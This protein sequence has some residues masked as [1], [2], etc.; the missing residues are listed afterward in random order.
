MVYFGDIDGRVGVVF[1]VLFVLGYI[2]I[3]EKGW[4]LLCEL[5]KH[6]EMVLFVYKYKNN[7]VFYDL[8]NMRDMILNEL[9]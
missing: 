6:E 2:G 1:Y 8:L 5:L 7:K 3:R 9:Y 4:S